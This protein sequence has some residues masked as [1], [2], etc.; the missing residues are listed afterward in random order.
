MEIGDILAVHDAGSEL[1]RHIEESFSA[2]GSQIAVHHVAIYLGTLG[3]I[4]ATVDCGVSLTALAD[5]IKGKAFTGYRYN[6]LD[7]TSQA[8]LV[9]E[10][11]GLIGEPYNM[12]FLE[13]HA[14]YYCSE[15]IQCIFNR[16]LG[17]D[18]FP[19]IPMCF[20]G[21]KDGFWDD[22]YRPSGLAI[23]HG[24]PGTHPGSLVAHPDLV[25]VYAFRSFEHGN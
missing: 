11:V 18:F 15:L 3:V 25:R 14:G 17:Y 1:G 16:V 7:N 24:H 23:P 19:S 21:A 2:S 13:D 10:A 20:S 12:W 4:D 22:Y 9:H 8:G 5:W 6:S